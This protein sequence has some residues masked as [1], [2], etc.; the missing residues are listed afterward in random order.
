MGEHVRFSPHVGYEREENRTAN[1]RR[2]AVN[3]GL[4]TLMS[5]VADSLDWKVSY[6]YD[7]N[8]LS[9]GSVDL[10]GHTID[11]SID[12]NLAPLDITFSLSG[13]YDYS[14]GRGDLSSERDRYELLAALSLTL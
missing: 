9:D 3:V 7:T 4:T 1:I 8:T 6:R 2:D 11:T 10:A 5:L 14:D 12:W 13:A